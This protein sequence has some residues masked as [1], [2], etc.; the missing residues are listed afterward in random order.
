MVI[1]YKCLE[2]FNF[3]RRIEKRLLYLYIRLRGAVGSVCVPVRSYLLSSSTYDYIYLSLETG[4]CLYLTC[5]SLDV[6]SS[7]VVLGNCRYCYVIAIAICYFGRKRC[8]QK[9]QFLS[10][11]IY[12]K[13]SVLPHRSVQNTFYSVTPDGY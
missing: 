10:I 1:R 11:Y 7:G 5:H 3:Q 12:V 8:D 9:K 4:D 6:H 2:Y 13:L